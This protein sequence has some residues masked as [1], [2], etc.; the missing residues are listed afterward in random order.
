MAQAAYVA[1]VNQAKKDLAAESGGKSAF[2]FFG[3]GRRAAAI[4][5][6][7]Q[8]ITGR[9]QVRDRS[10]PYLHVRLPY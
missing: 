9:G 8:A 1:M 10:F 7:Q 4:T 6:E 3:L 2:Q 5:Q